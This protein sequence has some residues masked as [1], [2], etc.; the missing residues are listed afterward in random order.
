MNNCRASTIESAGKRL[1]L[2]LANLHS[3]GE[4]NDVETITRPLFSEIAPFLKN[5][6][7]VLYIRDLPEATID[8]SYP[9]GHIYEEEIHI[10]VPAWPVD[11]M[12]LTN[13]I[14]HE[15]H[16][17]GRFQMARTPHTLGEAITSEGLAWYYAQLRSHWQAPWL[18]AALSD[19]LLKTIQSVW[20]AENYS[21]QELFYKGKY[22]RW[23]G[24]SVGYYLAK[25]VFENRF[26]LHA[27]LQ[28]SADVFKKS[29]DGCLFSE[30]GAKDRTSPS[31]NGM[32]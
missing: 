24:Y 30:T 12:P 31:H 7:H 6:R 23:I 1:I 2:L 10:A 8:G 19:E 25:K 21:H 9:K 17:L 13:T 3:S 14:A 27:S 26:D 16:R 20:D 15:L 22:G 4:I 5:Q 32:H 11:A 28:I 18:Q 29:L